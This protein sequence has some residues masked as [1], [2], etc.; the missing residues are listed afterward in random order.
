[1]EPFESFR[2][3][4]QTLFSMGLVKETEGNL[5]AFDGSVLRITRTGAP[6]GWLDPADVLDG[7]ITGSFRGASSDL[8]VH[9]AIYAERG[10]GA[11]AHG[12]PA[13]TVPVGGGG[14]GGHGVYAFAPTLDEA[15]ADSVRSARRH[16]S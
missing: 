8:E 13:G 2:R 16:A 12:H 3:A 14:P 11:V 1:V 7:E 6:L 9:R 4:G 15:V 5:S 10:P